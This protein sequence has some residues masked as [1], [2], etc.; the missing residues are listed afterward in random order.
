MFSKGIT[1]HNLRHLRQW[2][3]TMAY[4]LTK[5]AKKGEYKQ[6]RLLIA[7]FAGF[8]ASCS[9]NITF[10]ETYHLVPSEEK[11]RVRLDERLI[12]LTETA[13]AILGTETGEY[14]VGKALAYVLKNDPHSPVSLTYVFSEM[15]YSFNPASWFITP[16]VQA[17]Y[18][19]LV[20]VV[21]KER[22]ETVEVIGM[23]ASHVNSYRAYQ[24]AVENAVLLLGKKLA[25]LAPE[26]C[27][28]GVYTAC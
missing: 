15:R 13:S 10:E 3:Q 18:R 20:T 24:E 9:A 2:S 22:R 19:L 21:L 4:I 26:N 5:K 23:G 27:L 1:G 25:A 14:H 7:V 8:L 11:I 17:Q 12:N 6:R 16:G 28:Q